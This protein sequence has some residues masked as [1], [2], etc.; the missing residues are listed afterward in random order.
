[1]LG[2]P[3]RLYRNRGDGS[4]EDVAAELGVTGPRQSFPAWFWD[5]DN[6][7]NRLYRVVEGVEALEVVD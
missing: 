5:F 1:M 3:N 2:G 6:D 4:F 7:G